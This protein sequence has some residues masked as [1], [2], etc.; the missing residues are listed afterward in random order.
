MKEEILED[1]LAL[2][3]RMSKL[4]HE[5]MDEVAMLDAL[6]QAGVENWEGYE[7]AQQLYEGIRAGKSKEYK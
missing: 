2:V 1:L 3:S 6:R 4:I 7:E 5:L